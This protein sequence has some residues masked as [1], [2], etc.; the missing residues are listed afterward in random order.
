MA[1]WEDSPILIPKDQ[2]TSSLNDRLLTLSAFFLSVGRM[3]Q[4]REAAALKASLNKLTKL[5]A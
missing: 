2:T 4:E 5:C 1:I 3:E